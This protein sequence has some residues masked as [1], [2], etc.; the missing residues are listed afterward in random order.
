LASGFYFWKKLESKIFD[1]GVREYSLAAE[2]RILDIVDA[3]ISQL[4]VLAS[5]GKADKVNK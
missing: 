5:P 4:G 2:F 1:R 3:G